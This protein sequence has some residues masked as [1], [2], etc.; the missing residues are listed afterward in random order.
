MREWGNQ[1]LHDGERANM[2]ELL[3]EVDALREDASE[4]NKW[5]EGQAYLLKTTLADYK[6]LN[7]ASID[8][9]IERDKLRAEVA[10]LHEKYDLQRLVLTNEQYRAALEKLAKDA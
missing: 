4:R 5:I 8:I 6:K 10:R 7:D 1:L 9:T 3:A 2:M